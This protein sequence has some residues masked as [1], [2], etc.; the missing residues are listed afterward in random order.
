VAQRAVDDLGDLGLQRLRIALAAVAR[1]QHVGFRALA[2]CAPAPLLGRRRFAA[3]VATADQVEQRRG[4]LGAA[5]LRGLAQQR[6]DERR[7]VVRRRLLLV[8]AV[9]VGDTALA[10]EQQPD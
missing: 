6:A 7:R 5:W 9:V 1:E 10:R 2:E 8:L 4:E 3:V